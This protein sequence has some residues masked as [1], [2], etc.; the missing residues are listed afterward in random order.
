MSKQFSIK[1]GVYDDFRKI[2]EMDEFEFQ[3]LLIGKTRFVQ[4]YLMLIRNPS[5][6]N[7]NKQLA[8]ESNLRRNINDLFELGLIKNIHIN[9]SS[10]Q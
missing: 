5:Y 9:E 8:Y 10:N 6:M 3:R 7:Y 4:N 1:F 2:R